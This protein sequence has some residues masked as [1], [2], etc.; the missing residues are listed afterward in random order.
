LTVPLPVPLRSELIVMKLALLVAVQLHPLVVIT[1][2]LP[3]PPLASKDWL[4]GAILN[5]QAVIIKL[6]ALELPP[7]GAGLKTV[8]LAVPAVAMSAAVIAAV[9]C[10]LLIKVAIRSVPFHLTIE[11]LT[12]FDPLT[13]SVKAGPPAVVEG[14]AKLTKAGTG[15][16]TVTLAVALIPPKDAAVAVICTGP[17]TETPITPKLAEVAFAGIVTVAGTETTEVL[18]LESVTVVA[19]L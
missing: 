17:P 12:K 5:E 18:A 2:T 8:T 19:A 6:N 15:L 16:T 1:L 3:V 10:V 14:G 7:P 4:A 11:P 9:N 13:V